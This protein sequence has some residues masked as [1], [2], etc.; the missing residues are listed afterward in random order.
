MTV[1]RLQDETTESP[2][3]SRP[4]YVI[5]M[6][7]PL[8]RDPDVPGERSAPPQDAAFLPFPEGQKEATSFQKAPG[9]WDQ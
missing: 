1:Y 4:R 6:T 2:A 7:D 5:T 3:S 9:S 8:G